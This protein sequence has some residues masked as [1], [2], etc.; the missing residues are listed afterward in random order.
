MI[1][2]EFVTASKKRIME[3]IMSSQWCSKIV[4]NSAME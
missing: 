4:R 3:T 2:E 1:L